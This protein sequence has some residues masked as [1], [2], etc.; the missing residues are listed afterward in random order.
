MFKSKTAKQMIPLSKTFFGRNASSNT[1]KASVLNLRSMNMYDVLYLLFY[2]VYR[3]SDVSKKMYEEFR[4]QDKAE[5]QLTSKLGVYNF[6]NE[7][8]IAE[9]IFTRKVEAIGPVPFYI[10]FLRKEQV[11]FSKYDEIHQ[12]GKNGILTAAEV[13]KDYQNNLMHNNTTGKGQYPEAA[14]LIKGS[15]EEV[16]MAK[17][18]EIFASVD[19]YPNQNK[20]F[21]KGDNELIA[22]AT[23]SKKVLDEVG[24]MKFDALKEITK[25]DKFQPDFKIHHRLRGPSFGTINLDESNKEEADQEPSNNFPKL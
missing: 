14:V 20:C 3:K 9:I 19:C 21:I 7:M 2:N 25:L 15:S 24:Y 23:N 13:I 22:F 1:D 12:T 5:G 18:Q 8:Q 10:D 6:P 17:A 11:D 4:Q 16:R